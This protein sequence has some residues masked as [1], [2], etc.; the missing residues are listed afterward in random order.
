[1]RASFS[2]PEGPRIW[3][4]VP[5]VLPL[6]VLVLAPFPL[7][8]H[9]GVFLGGAAFALFHLVGAIPWWRQSRRRSVE[10][11]AGPGYLDVQNAGTRNQRIFAKN[12]TGASTARAQA[13]VLF[14][15]SH[16]K[17]AQPLSIEVESEADA[18]HLRH[19]LGI[20][21]GGTGTLAWRTVPSTNAKGG[22]IG[23]IVVVVLV[24]I[25]LSLA[26]GFGVAAAAATAFV[27]AQFVLVAAIMGL[28]ELREKPA[29]PTVMMTSEGLWCMTT[30]GA[31]RVPYG[32]VLDVEDTGDMLVF[33]V[34]SPPF[35]LYVRK[36]KPY[37]APGLSK[38]DASALVAQI[39]AAAE[40]ARG[41]G[42]AKVE[43]VGRVDALRRNGAR[44]QDWLA[45]LDMTG[46]TLAAS[47]GYRGHDIAAEDLWN[48]LEDPEADAEL[49]VAA[50]RTLRSCGEP[51]T[52][53]R[54]DAAVAAVREETTTA[55]LRIALDDDLA[56]ET[57]LLEADDLAVTA[58]APRLRLQEKR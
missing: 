43:P 25:F 51:G 17:R 13:G 9:S 40:R 57:A 50:A 3:R 49:R 34:P 58:A 44:A 10:L 33:S 56:E 55:R 2:D 29:D 41:L 20:G 32:H 19:A 47:G 11:T 46:K 28:A 16:E 8:N 7:G 37:C 31:M 22:F 5:Y 14:S 4:V 38:E 54:I 35:R 48:L 30:Q 52:A 21:H 12:I 45:R 24:A 1:M 53:E 23:R 18:D 36:T 39:R 6:L 42:V 26:G 15:L 27:M